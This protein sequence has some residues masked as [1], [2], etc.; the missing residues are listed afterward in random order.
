MG[1]D[2]A[3]QD[4]VRSTAEDLV[5]KADEFDTIEAQKARLDASDPRTLELA[6]QATRLAREMAAKAEMEEQLIRESQ[7]AAKDPGVRSD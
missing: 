7:A 6:E 4:D 3:R 5:A 2:Q 1:R